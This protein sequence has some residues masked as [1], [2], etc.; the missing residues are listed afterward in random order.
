[1]K[2]L[3]IAAILSLAATFAYA[4]DDEPQLGQ[5]CSIE[6][7]K[8]LWACLRNESEKI[9]EANL[10]NEII[11]T[12]SEAGRESL[13]TLLG[14]KTKL[15]QQ[16]QEAKAFVL[17]VQYQDEPQ[18]FYYTLTAQGEL[19]PLYEVNLIDMP[20]IF[21][22]LKDK[23]LIYMKAMKISDVLKEWLEQIEFDQE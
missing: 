20:Y 18:L 10:P 5:V 9:W 4:S 14:S 15:A 19:K 2:H 21:K 17:I 12:I 11:Y 22:N 3:I 8:S 6:S 13:L 23:S 7:K 1:M 16:I